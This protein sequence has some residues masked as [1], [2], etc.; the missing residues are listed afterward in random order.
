MKIETQSIH[1]GRKVDAATGAIAPPIHL[2]TTYERDA[3]GEYSRGYFYGRYGNPNRDA[4]EGA[5]CEIEGGAEAAIFASGSTTIMTLL[6]A[7]V[8]GDHVIAA[9]DLYFGIRR[10]LTEI[11]GAWGLETSLVDMTDLAAVKAAV[12]PNTKLILIETPSNPL[13]KVTDIQAVADIAHAAGAYLACDSTFASPVLQRGFQHGADFV[14]HSMT[15]FIGGHHDVLGGIIIAKE[16]NPL[17][18]RIR[19]LQH[20]AGA[21]PS[22]FECWLVQRGLPTMAYRVRGHS[23]NALRVAQFLE[24]HPQIERVLYPGLASHP[25]HE[26]AQ[27]QMTLFGGMMSALVKGSGEDALA[28]TGRVK[29]FTRATSFGSPHSLIEHR[30]SVESGQTTTPPNLLRLSIGLEHID[31]LL[32]DLDQ[33]LSS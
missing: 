23:E 7:L 22:P 33:A 15:K 32:A 17:F 21:V 6:Q 27:K 14:I 9:D 1:A 29:V 11:F 30:A 2:S 20:I 31:D 25:Q 8:A 19:A 3:D 4:V 24:T 28:V 26:I 16:L 18:E 12:R 13:T 10:L 5:L